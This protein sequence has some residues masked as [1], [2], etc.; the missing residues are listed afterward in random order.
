MTKQEKQFLHR[1]YMREYRKRDLEKERKKRIW[2]RSVE[3]FCY[4][5]FRDSFTSQ[6]TR[7]FNV[8]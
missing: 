2:N 1:N 3:S 8:S 6:L 5:L 7:L 4:F